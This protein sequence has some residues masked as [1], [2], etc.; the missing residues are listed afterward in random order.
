[1]FHHTG[2]PCFTYSC[3]WAFACF[4]NYEHVCVFEQACYMLRYGQVARRGCGDFL[5]WSLCTFCI[6]IGH[7]QA[8]G[9]QRPFLSFL[10]GVSLSA[11]QARLGLGRGARPRQYCLELVGSWC[12]WRMKPRTTRGGVTVEAACP[13]FCSFWCSDVFRVSS[14]SGGLVSGFRRSCRPSLVFGS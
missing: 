6:M 1:M 3:W 10:D 13:R 14:L 7:T 2:R 9:Q 5:R 12:H 11:T 8:W 4:D